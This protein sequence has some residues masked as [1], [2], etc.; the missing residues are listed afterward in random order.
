MKIAWTSSNDEK[1][2]RTTSTGTSESRRLDH[3][4]P[5]VCAHHTER[6]TKEPDPGGNNTIALGSE[7]EGNPYSTILLKLRG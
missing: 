1:K 5:G 3:A 6:D 4:T 7:L 2:R